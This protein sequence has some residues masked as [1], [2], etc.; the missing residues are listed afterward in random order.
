MAA[1]QSIQEEAPNNGGVGV[2][3]KVNINF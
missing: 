1:D 3:R 2:V